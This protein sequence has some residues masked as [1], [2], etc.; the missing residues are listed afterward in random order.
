MN[1]DIYLNDTI[2]YKKSFY[3]DK[4]YPFWINECGHTYC[5][6]NYYVKRGVTSYYTIEYIISGKGYIQE[7]DI[8]SYPCAGDTHIF[9]SGSTQTFYCNADDPWEKI[10]IIFYGPLADSLFEMYGL[11]QHLFFKG[12]NMREPIEKIIELCNSDLYPDYELMSR[13]STIVFDMIQQLYLYK[14]K[15]ELELLSLSVAD[16]LKILIDN[17]WDYTMSLNDL[18]K[19]LYCSRN[20]AIRLFSEKFKISPYKYM[21]NQRLKNAKRMLA[22]SNIP[23]SDVAKNMGFCDSRYFANWFKQRTE[24]TPSEYR[25]SHQNTDK[26]V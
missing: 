21:S 26:D 19:Q 10:W 22:T 13:C 15:N 8:V 7:N 25:K 6:P 18:T 14:C 16:K 1:E 17:M 20:Y 3:A 4:T 23:V 24:H 2:E 12:L 11:N 5:G 9:H